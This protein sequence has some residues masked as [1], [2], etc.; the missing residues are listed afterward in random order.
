MVSAIE[1]DSIFKRLETGDLRFSCFIEES[2]IICNEDYLC[3]ITV[4]YPNN[5]IML[6]NVQSTRNPSYYNAS[7]IDTSVIGYH[8]YQSFCTNG[9]DAGYSDKQYF[10]I[11][12][13]GSEPTTTQGILYFIILLVSIGLFI[14]SL[15]GAINIPWKNNRSP[16]GIIVGVNSL[17]YVK[18]SLWFV[19]Y[20]VLLWVSYILWGINRSFLFSEFTGEI[21]KFIFYALMSSALPLFVLTTFVL[22]T[23]WIKDSKITEFLSRG[24]VMR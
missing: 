23:A 12:P 5:S 7:I 14:L 1:P 11:T 4:K 16:D 3:N 15:Y 8:Q 22:I 17:K 13:T 20:M 24:L 19:S 2:G 18:V 9:T 6:N 10:L 21:F